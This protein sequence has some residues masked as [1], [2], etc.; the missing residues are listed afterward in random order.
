MPYESDTAAIYD[1]YFPPDRSPEADLWVRL[2]GPAATHLLEPMIGTGEVALL[3]ASRGYHVT[4]V[5]L[6]L[7]MLEV[8]AKRREAAGPEVCQRLTLVQGDISRVVLPL[9]HFDLAY[10]SHGSWHLLAERR[11]RMDA[12]RAVR[13]S[14]RPGGKLAMELFPPLKSSGRS[15]PRSFRPFR[16]TPPELDV[17]KTSQLERDAEEQVMRIHEVLTVNGQVTENHLLLQLLTPE[18]IRAELKRAGFSQVELYG[19]FDLEPYSEGAPMI[20]TVATV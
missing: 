14:L 11:L 18:Q 12:L 15:E 16:P 17:V 9:D 3:L 8:C 4:G 1:L 10:V 2:A 7:P 13:R 19:N 6:S 20:L 5:D